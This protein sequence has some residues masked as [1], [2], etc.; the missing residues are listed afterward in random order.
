MDQYALFGS[1]DLFREDPGYFLLAEDDPKFFV[2]LT[3]GI[4][5]LDELPSTLAFELQELGLSRDELFEVLKD[6]VDGPNSDD[7]NSAPPSD[8]L[9][10]EDMENYDLLSLSGSHVIE[11]SINP[12][13]II[14]YETA[15]ASE[16]FE[17][18]FFAYDELSAL[19]HSEEDYS[20]EY[21]EE[22][23][24]VNPDSV[25]NE[26]YYPSYNEDEFTGI[27]GGRELTI[28]SGEYE[29]S[30]L[31]YESLILLPQTAF[32]FLVI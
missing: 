9:T 30:D 13:L 5:N 12:D 4:S 27:L 32:L 26:T 1:L 29:L 20:H 6:M 2:R 7:P 10:E 8:E 21:P 25:D 31:P 16:L 22:D 15:S 28:G 24:G 11:G 18:F 17:E 3:Q 23:E 19:D 14:S